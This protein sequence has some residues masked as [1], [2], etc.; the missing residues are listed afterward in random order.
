M[1]EI[2]KYGAF[3]GVFTPSLLT[4]LGVIM[5]MRL[6]W[7]VGEAGLVYAIGIILFAHVISITTGLSI[8]SIATDKKIKTGGIYYML[9]RSLGLPMGG[10]IGI[11]LFIGTALSISLYIVGFAENF[12]SIEFIQN[13]T[14]LGQDINSFRIVGTII[15]ILL[16][17][18]AFIS[19][20]LAMRMQFFILIAIALSLISIFVGFF[21]HGEY[22][23]ETV[24]LFGAGSTSIEVVFAIFFP[25]VT[26]FTAGVAMSGDLR[27]PKGDIPKGTILSIVVGLIIYISLAVAIAFYIDPKYLLNDYNILSKIAWFAPLVIAGIWGATLSSALGGILGGP[28]ILQAI[29]LDK[30]APKVFGKGYGE[31]NEPRNALLLIFAIAEGGILIGELDLIAKIVSMFYLASYGFINLAYVLEKWAST[32]FRPSFKIHISLGIIGFV[33]S[34]AIMF[35]LDATSMFAALTIMG[36]IYL[37]LKRKQIKSEYGDV[38]QSVWT[39][40]MRRAL[41]KM[42]EKEIEERNWKPNIILFSGQTEKRPHLLE[43]GKCLVGKH[44]ML[45]NFDLV[46]NKELDVL[47]S[48]QNQAVNTEE[49]IPGVFT[50]RQSCKDIYDGIEMIART[51][52]FSGVEPNTILIGL[53]EKRDKAERFVKL[54]NTLNGLDYNLLLMDYDKKRGFGEKKQID[55]WAKDSDNYGNFALVISKFLTNH[56]IW[57]NAKL[58]FLVVNNNNANA[59][60]IKKKAEAHLDKLRIDAEILVVNNEIEKKSF[61]EIVT[62]ESYHSDLVFVGI[63]EIEKGREKEYI[64]KTSKLFNDIGTVILVKASS[65]FKHL[66]LDSTSGKINENDKIEPFIK[67]IID[68]KGFILPNN[69]LLAE[70]QKHL[71]Q[72]LSDNYNNSLNGFFT[73]LTNIGVSSIE[74]TKELVN[75]S[76]D[77]IKAHYSK[78]DVSKQKFLINQN[79]NN[80]LLRTNKLIESY[81]K[82]TSPELKEFFKTSLDTFIQENQKILNNLPKKIKITY[83][84]DEL[85]PND[86]DKISEKLFKAS[87]R[88]FKNY[89]YKVR[90]RELAKTK[91]ELQTYKNTHKYISDFGMLN[92]QLIVEFQ[93]LI[94]EINNAF[95]LLYA[96]AENNELND[97]TIDETYNNIITKL[98]NI[99][100]FSKSINTT[101]SDNFYNNTKLNLNKIS[102][103]LNQVNCNRYVVELNHNKKINVLKKSFKNITETWMY[104]NTLL[105]NAISTELRLF[106]LDSRVKTFL[107]DFTFKTKTQINNNLVAELERFNKYV[108]GINNNIDK[109]VESFDIEFDEQAFENLI[110]TIGEYQEHLVKALNRA[111]SNFPEKIEVIDLDEFNQFENIQLKGA[112]AIKISASRLLEY[113]FLNKLENP[114]NKEFNELKNKLELSHELLSDTR[115]LIEF[116]IS[117]FNIDNKNA[118]ENKEIEELIKDKAV[119]INS[120]LT[121]L[122][123]LIENINNISNSLSSEISHELKYYTFVKTASNLKQYISKQEIKKKK[124]VL[125]TKFINLKKLYSKQLSRL[126]FAKSKAIN[127][128]KEI[129]DKDTILYSNINAILN[130]KNAFSPDEEIINSVPLYYRQLFSNKNSYH[131]EFWIG[132]ENELE[133]AKNSINRYYTGYKGAIAIIGEPG[134]GKSFF[135]NYISKNFGNNT[136][137]NITPPKSGTINIKNFEEILSSIIDKTGSSYEL[138]RKFEKDSIIILDD[139]ELWWEKSENGNQLVEH[140]FSLINKYNKRFLF[141]ISLNSYSAE[142]IFKLNPIK[143]LFINIIKLNSLSSETIKDIVLLRHK[144]SGLELNHKG[145]KLTENNRISLAKLF[146]KYYKYSGGNVNS[147]LNLWLA[148]ITKY[149]KNTVFTDFKTVDTFDLNRLDTESLLYLTQ[150]VIHKNI[151]Q[152]KL[153]RI[154]HSDKNLT[155]QKIKYLLRT[156]LIS[157][158]NNVYSIDKFMMAS[159]LK[160]LKEKGI[161]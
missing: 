11:A 9:S 72:K 83:T 102:A 6:G 51:Y 101:L 47:F 70:E 123:E 39:S 117:D 42:S 22:H 34:F 116:S 43:F 60:I 30:I 105:N 138:F 58:R 48:K 104:N 1:P 79:Q 134:S 56:K 4:I 54:I 145:K 121:Y 110:H 106:A 142:L 53:G 31:T 64:E 148:N 139:F 112:K 44:G 23:P 155:S 103:R 128:K 159:V 151:T 137:Y 62:T 131:K 13:F 85:A 144:S 2:K 74:N 26:G 24:K 157:K 129:E 27:N 46:E 89:K 99:H 37:L 115:R 71:Y 21:I 55:I 65:V 7:V 67:K 132:R 149:E 12:L 69:E 45:S 8:S 109:N 147:A 100:K 156:G 94:A 87:R 33:A 135:T 161:L 113:L 40:V 126:I 32:D 153:A 95:I 68:D 57:E 152:I 5:Y 50:R 114:L 36:G 108:K 25:A 154:M 130:I 160:L 136:I 75:N 52:G 120:E 76:F 29:S 41:Q 118:N 15:I 10:S 49:N 88:L 66:Q 125:T 158:Q 140:L 127:L 150:F 96:K 28:R 19:T 111:S 38:W 143:D 98:D 63:P 84:T 17:I 77:T 93:K 82:D 91:I 122:K 146:S 107:G 16:T 97:K 119:K 3:A 73:E 20:S 90:Y 78:F 59:P 14:G 80:L 61:Y 141:I 124:R 92:V 86:K 133:S 81:I 35:K 18:I